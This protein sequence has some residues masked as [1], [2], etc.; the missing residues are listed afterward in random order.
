VPELQDRICF[1]SG[2]LWTFMILTVSCY[3]L[4]NLDSCIRYSLQIQHSVG[5]LWISFGSWGPDSAANEDS[6]WFWWVS[7]QYFCLCRPLFYTKCWSV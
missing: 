3:W 6:R 4:Q 7:H 5:I 1:I 2:V